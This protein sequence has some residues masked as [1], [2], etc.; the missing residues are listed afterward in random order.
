MLAFLFTGLYKLMN[1]LSE[2]KT[3]KLAGAKHLQLVEQLS[4]FPTDIFKLA[5][6]LEVLDLSNN[7]LTIDS[8][9]DQINL[10]E[11]YQYSVSIE[12][13]CGIVDAQNE[14]T[15]LVNECEC[16][17]NMPNVFSPNGDEFNNHGIKFG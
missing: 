15:L 14:I 2:L 8:I 13:T 10:N 17:L 7:N 12:N 9:I 5:D 4:E 16:E 1:T 11:E 3:G 6:T